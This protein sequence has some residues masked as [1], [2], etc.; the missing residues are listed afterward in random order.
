MT[1][2][3]TH[4]GGEKGQT[5][6]AYKLTRLKMPD[7]LSGQSVLDIGC[8]EGF[9]CDQAARRGATRVL[10]IDV[11]DT[12]L[13][14][15]KSRYESDT[16]K[17]RKKSWTDLPSGEYD[18]ILW[19]SAMHYELDPG[20]ILRDIAERLSPDGLFVLECGM[21]LH[22]GKAMR[23]VVRHDG[24]LWYPTKDFIERTLRDAGLSFRLV[25]EAEQVGTDPV[26]R[27]VYHCKPRVPFV[28][29]IT[30]ETKAGKSALT[31]SLFSACTKVIALD[32]FVS[33]IAWGK[34]QHTPLEQLLRQTVD[35]NDLGRLFRG[36]DEAGLTDAYA[37][38]L[39]KAVASTDE[40]VVF[41][42]FMTD[43]QQELLTQKLSSRARVW[44]VSRAKSGGL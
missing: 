12:F 5:D 20:K 38:L 33:T 14:E 39:A 41:E 40:I 32:H 43:L 17:F 27:V 13:A 26:P 23:Y 31:A 8:N 44:N 9:F 29:L 30:G 21:L 28:L 42:G 35:L 34:W 25:S 1:T 2:H 7:D 36:I 15:A 11:N 4:I 24:G 37:T 16:I 22:P 3:Q 18:L 19:T 10:G 6:S